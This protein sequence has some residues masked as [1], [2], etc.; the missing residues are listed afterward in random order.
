[1]TTQSNSIGIAAARRVAI[2]AQSLHQGQSLF[3]DTPSP[4][5]SSPINARQINACIDAMALLQIDA[6]NTIIRS[7]YM[8]LYSRLGH[9]STSKLDDLVFDQSAQRQSKRRYFEYWGHECSVMPLSYFPLLRWRM[10]DARRGVGVY[11]QLAQFAKK[12]STYVSRIKKTVAEQGPIS[13]RQLDGSK[14]GP[15]MWEW[16]KSKQA[17][18]YLFWSG[19]VTTKGRSG[20]ARLYDLT[21]NSIPQDVLDVEVS[22]EDAIA[23]LLVKGVKAM[24]VATTSDIRDYFR[25]NAKEANALIPRLLEEQ[26]IIE[27][28]VE[29]WKQPAYCM[30][31][32]K[33]PRQSKA[34]ALLTP[35][36]PLV[37]C[38]QRILRLF[39]FDYKIEIYVPES[40]RRYGYYVL[41]FILGDNIVA[42][43][44]LK[45]HRDHSQLEVKG[46]WL[47]ADANIEHTAGALTASLCQ[48]ASWLD[49]NEIMV[50]G[51]GVL[52]EQL[53]AG[54]AALA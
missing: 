18:E 19:Q 29:G 15:G 47:E 1:M 33:I 2:K 6:I 21:E 8:P 11:S 4:P 30:P 26:R 13:S 32:L 28:E 9:Y 27:I 50:T 42:R 3:G 49:L 48:L 52:P 36:D 34:Q 44:D 10:E 38:R 54:L 35:F 43:V 31:E 14:R 37:W 53:S 45:A 24:G 23:E 12:E 40:K 25:I 16:S 17:L 7:H 39:D 22:R 46:A 51:R 5:L 20:F 41:P